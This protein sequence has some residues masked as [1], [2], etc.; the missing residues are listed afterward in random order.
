MEQFASFKDRADA[1]HQ[2]AQVLIHLQ[3]ERTV[4]L[5]IP[6]GGLPIGE[7][8]SRQLNSQLKSI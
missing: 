8:I 2:L 5:A 4:I 1:G 7:Q 6:N 3:N